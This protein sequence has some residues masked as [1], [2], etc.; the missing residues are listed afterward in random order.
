MTVIESSTGVDVATLLR[1][2]R[3]PRAISPGARPSNA[4]R[5]PRDS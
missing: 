1:R 5:P 3:R 2:V 4:T